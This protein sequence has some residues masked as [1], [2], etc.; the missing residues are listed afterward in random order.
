[1]PAGTGQSVRSAQ[2]TAGVSAGS[3]SALLPAALGRVPLQDKR[4]KPQNPADARRTGAKRGQRVP[5]CKGKQQKLRPHK[6]CARRKNK[7]TTTTTTKQNVNIIE[8]SGL[9]P[10]RRRPTGR[11]RSPTQWKGSGQAVLRVAPEEPH[12]W[13][14]CPA[15]SPRQKASQGPRRPGKARRPRMTTRSEERPQAAAPEARAAR[16][17]RRTAAARAPRRA[18]ARG[19]RQKR[20]PRI[21]ILTFFRF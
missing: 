15:S 21:L 9:R 1:M 7:S 13:L 6:S 17:G 18:G 5:T 11:G 19:R 8:W 2:Q 3:P 16:R 10:A 4:R 14:A 20:P 12:A